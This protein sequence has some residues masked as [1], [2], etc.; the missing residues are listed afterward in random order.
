MVKDEIS[1]DIQYVMTGMKVDDSVAYIKFCCFFHQSYYK[2][3]QHTQRR[4]SK[5]LTGKRTWLP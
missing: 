5:I 3:T 2:L 1:K 4:C